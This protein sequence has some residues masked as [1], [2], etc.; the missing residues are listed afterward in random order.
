MQRGKSSASHILAGRIGKI[1]IVSSITGHQKPMKNRNPYVQK[2]SL[3]LFSPFCFL[4]HVV[5]RERRALS[6]FVVWGDLA[7][8][9][10]KVDKA[11][12]WINLPLA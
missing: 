11:V 7:L 10:Q 5:V 2:L 8:V 12:H 1:E 4:R 6:G 9:V 3:V